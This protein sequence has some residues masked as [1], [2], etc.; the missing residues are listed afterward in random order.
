[1]IFKSLVA[2]SIIGMGTILTS[3]YLT[4]EVTSD[5]FM[6]DNDI[7]FVKRIDDVGSNENML[8]LVASSQ[9]SEQSETK[10][11]FRKEINSILRDFIVNSKWHATRVSNDKDEEYRINKE[12]KIE[13]IKMGVNGEVLIPEL[14]KSPFYVS[15][16]TESTIALWRFTDSGFEIVEA[17]KIFENN[18]APTQSDSS[19]SSN[20]QDDSNIEEEVLELKLINVIKPNMTDVLGIKDVIGSASISTG[21]MFNFNVSIQKAVN[22]KIDFAEIKGNTFS[23]ESEDQIYTGTVYKSGNGEIA[24]N[25]VNGPNAGIKFIFM[26]EHD[27]YE[28]INTDQNTTEEQQTKQDLPQELKDNTN[29]IYTE[30]EQQAAVQEREEKQDNFGFNFSDNQPEQKTEEQQPDM[31]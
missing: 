13:V 28:K 23:Y 4:H 1:M 18:Q 21:A 27:F 6:L 22:I 30:E 7:K 19:D 26:Q 25:L 3:S 12:V 14:S 2:L 5:K 16:N 17:E 29:V 15:L 10:T 24:I 31:Q 8:R 20:Q 11:P 9:K